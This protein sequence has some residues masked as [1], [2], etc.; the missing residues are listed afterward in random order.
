MSVLGAMLV[1]ACDAD[2]RPC[3]GLRGDAFGLGP[4][5]LREQEL[6]VLACV[7]AEQAAQNAAQN[8]RLEQRVHPR[9]PAIGG[10]PVK[11][12]GLAGG[13]LANVAQADPHLI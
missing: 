9:R 6:Q 11:N 7:A 1:L 2:D 12:P 5:G 3:R 8:A 13:E 10:D 4:D